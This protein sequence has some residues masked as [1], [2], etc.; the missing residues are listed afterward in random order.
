M[1][2]SAL[3]LYEILTFLEALNIL[4]WQLIK[5]LPFFGKLK[6]FSKKLFEENDANFC[7]KH[8]LFSLFDMNKGFV[9]IKSQFLNVEVYYCV[10]FTSKTC[11]NTRVFTIQPPSTNVKLCLRVPNEKT[12]EIIIC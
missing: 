10:Y 9:S 4:L 11:M 6:E 8:F 3:F 2:F 12:F 1:V 5:C 7:R